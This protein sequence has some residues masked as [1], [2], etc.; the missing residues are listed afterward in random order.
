[1]DEPLHAVSRDERGQVFLVIVI[2]WE[3]IF[4][5]L[6]IC[7][8]F[9]YLIDLRNNA[10]EKKLRVLCGNITY[11]VSIIFFPMFQNVVFILDPA[12]L[13]RKTHCE[14]LPKILLSSS[15]SDREPVEPI[16]P[17]QPYLELENGTLSCAYCGKNYKL[18][19]SLKNHL[20]KNHALIDVVTFQCAV[21]RKC[22]DTKFKLTRHNKTC[23]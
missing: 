11:L 18:I 15:D 14:M 7:R 6:T 5:P 4:L 22:F 3:H 10:K 1:M 2:Q 19:G 21:C 23:K 20:A 16:N 9:L 12:C 8:F 13:E 17:P